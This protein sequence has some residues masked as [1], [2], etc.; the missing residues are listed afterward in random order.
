MTRFPD[1]DEPDL[2]AEILLRP[3]RPRPATPPTW[4]RLR[5]RST[6]RRRFT[7]WPVPDE[8]LIQLAEV[9]TA[10]GGNGVPAART[11]PTASASSCWSAGPCGSRSGD[12]SV[13]AEQRDW[14]DRRDS[15]GV[16][17]DTVPVGT[18]TVE[19]HPV[20]SATGL[21]PTTAGEIESTDGLMV[22]C[23]TPTTPPAWLSAGEGLSAMWL[24]AT[25]DGL[26]VVPL[27]QVVEVPETRDALQLEVLG[28]LARPPAPGPRRLAGD[29]PQ[30]APAHAAPTRRRGP[31][32]A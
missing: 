3:R 21:S 15:A 32:A 31:R 4:R 27:S 11:S 24:H 29:Q 14:L 9:A 5:S 20:A 22:L 25:G 16:P 30:P 19:S 13:A 18:A 10:W 1:P 6:D 23:A 26:S 2:L 12:A 17:L 8:R 28:G 7:S